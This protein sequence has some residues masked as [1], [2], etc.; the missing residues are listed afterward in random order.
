MKP[1]VG[2]TPA[3]HDIRNTRRGG[4]WAIPVVTH[5]EP[6][7]HLTR[8]Q[9]PMDAPG[10]PYPE[11]V[12]EVAVERALRRREPVGRSLTRAERLAVARR[13]VAAGQ[14]VNAIAQYTRCNNT[15]ARSLYYAITAQ[16]EL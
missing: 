14:G 10:A 9:R 7:P 15:E 1:L 11:W 16:E 12:D 3:I 5:R 6:P 4:R 8:T 13:L 2:S